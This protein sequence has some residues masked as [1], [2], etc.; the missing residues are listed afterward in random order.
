MHSKLLWFSSLVWVAM[1]NCS[2]A[3]AERGVV[4]P[5]TRA[6]VQS[7]VGNGFRVDS[8]FGGF[9]DEEVSLNGERIDSGEVETIY[10]GLDSSGAPGETRF[11]SRAYAQTG[12]LRLGAFAAAEVIDPLVND[13]NPVY[14]ND[15]FT[16][17]PAGVPDSFATFGSSYL[18][19]E[20]NVLSDAAVDHVRFHVSIRGRIEIPDG[21]TRDRANVSAYYAEFLGEWPAWPR[22]APLYFWGN[23]AHSADLWTDPIPVVDGRFGF[24]F[25]ITSQIFANVRSPEDEERDWSFVVD[26]FDGVTINHLQGFDRSGQPVSLASATGYNGTR[27]PTVPVPEP[28]P[29]MALLGGLGVL[30]AFLGTRREGRLQR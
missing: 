26:F 2:V 7:W 28:S 19:D 20:V 3:N 16:L 30:L 22:Q 29:L 5:Q 21:F 14:I 25:G 23:G 4:K 27:Y 9:G 10:R 8:I 6:G 12:R 18:A 11:R 17:N 15:D 13:V 1:L 24:G